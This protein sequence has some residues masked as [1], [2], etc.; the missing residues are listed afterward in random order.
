MISQSED[1]DVDPL[2]SVSLLTAPLPTVWVKLGLKKKNVKTGLQNLNRVK[3]VL[4]QLKPVV[5]HKR[6]PVVS[7]KVLSL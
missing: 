2:Q 3:S 6:L 1:P 5:C 4:I 7:Q